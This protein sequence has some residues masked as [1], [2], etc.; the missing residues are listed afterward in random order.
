M[1]QPTAEDYEYGRDPATSSEVAELRARV[2]ALEQV[3]ATLAWADPVMARRVKASETKTPEEYVERLA[4][5]IR[6]K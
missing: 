6:A 1:C 3:V 4:E 2:A 5:N